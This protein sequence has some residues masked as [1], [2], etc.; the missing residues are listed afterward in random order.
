ML[1]YPCLCWSNHC[2]FLCCYFPS[3][4]VTLSNYLR[5]P[6]H[7]VIKLTANSWT[8]SFWMSAATRPTSIHI[9]RLA[10]RTATLYPSRGAPP[11]DSGAPHST[12]ME[13]GPRATISKGAV[14]WVG[15]PINEIMIVVFFVYGENFEK[16]FLAISGKNYFISQVKSKTCGNY[17]KLFKKMRWRI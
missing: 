15:G 2:A 17:I 16:D 5:F 1:C 3:K 8:L 10:S 6:Y 4:K 7:V 13:C 9:W 12:I 14:G 11:S